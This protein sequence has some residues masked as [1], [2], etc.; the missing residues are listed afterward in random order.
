LAA[1]NPNCSI[2][3]IRAGFAIPN[4][5]LNDIDFIVICADKL[6][7]EISGEPTRLQFQL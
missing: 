4:A 6:S 3:K 1:V 7:A 5:E 2:A